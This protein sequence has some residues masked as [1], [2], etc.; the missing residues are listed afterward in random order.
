MHKRLILM[1]IV[2]LG[3]A[4]FCCGPALAASPWLLMGSAVPVQAAHSPN[5]LAVE[6]RCEHGS[7]S[8]GIKF[9][10]PAGHL[11]FAGISNLSIDYR[12]KN[13]STCLRDSPRLLLELDTNGDGMA[14]KDIVVYLGPPPNLAACGK[15]WTATGNL[16][17]STAKRFNTS[18]FDGGTAFDTYADASRLAG[19]DAVVDILLLVD[20]GTRDSHQ[21]VVVDRMQV[22]QFRLDAQS[23]NR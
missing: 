12:I 2:T 11:T 10:A 19:K 21:N 9:D 3:P 6:I 1:M 7:P 22:N 8:G 20:G 23:F 14:D 17:K 4:L 13:G 18:Q 16:I 15:N 5:H